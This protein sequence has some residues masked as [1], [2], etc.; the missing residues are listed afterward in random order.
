MR[1]YHDY[2]GEEAKT[3]QVL[4]PLLEMVWSELERVPLWSLRLVGEKARVLDEEA[5]FGERDMYYDALALRGVIA[6]LLLVEWVVGGEKPYDEKFEQWV[7]MATE[8]NRLQKDGSAKQK[9]EWK[10]EH[11]R[12]FR[13]AIL[14]RMLWDVVTGEDGEHS[15]EYNFVDMPGES[16]EA[17]KM[18]REKAMVKKEV[19]R[20]DLTKVDK[21]SLAYSGDYS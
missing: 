8:W 13:K 20:V 2:N 4:K 7:E 17:V 21:N 18:W 6:N 14:G 12:D 3:R 5:R 15:W 19:M 9:K 11:K 10:K 1:R 16:S